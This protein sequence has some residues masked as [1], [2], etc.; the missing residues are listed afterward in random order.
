MGETNEHMD[1]ESYMDFENDIFYEAMEWAVDNIFKRIWLDEKWSKPAKGGRHPANPS[2]EKHKDME[3]QVHIFSGCAMAMRVLDYYYKQK[4]DKIPKSNVENLLKR[5]IFGYLYHD[6][7]KLT[8]TDYLMRD[9]EPLLN[10]VKETLGDLLVEL[11]LTSEDVYQIATCTEKGTSFNI[12]SNEINRNNLQFESDFSR[13]ADSLSGRFNDNV[14]GP[15]ND[16]TFGADIIISGKE[17]AHIFVANTSMVAVTD[18]VRKSCISVIESDPNNFFLWSDFNKLYYKSSGVKSDQASLR[19]RILKTFVENAQRSMRPENLL[20]LNDRTVDNSASGFVAQTVESL[21]SFMENETGQGMKMCVYLEDIKLDSPEKSI[22][23]EKY[24]EALSSY[25]TSSFSLNYKFVRAKKEGHSLRDGLS[26]NSYDPSQEDERLHIFLIRYTQLKST[27]NSN[28]AKVVRDHIDL[29]IDRNLDLLKHLVGKEPRKSVLVFPQ[30]LNDKDI[31]WDILLQDV[32]KDLNVERKDIDNEG[33]MRKVLPGLF[34][35]SEFPEVPSKFSMSM[36]NGYPA[37]EEGKGDKLFGINTN[38]FNNRLPTSKIGFGKVD[39]LSIYEYSLRRNSL[40]N[41]HSKGTFTYLRFP[42]AIPHL[43]LTYI[44]NKVTSSG[45]GERLLLNNIDLSID[46]GN[47][48]LTNQISSSDSILV[49][50][51][52]IGKEN[53]VIRSLYQTIEFAMKTKMH[54][55]VSYANA[56]IFDDQNEALRFEISSSILS[57]FSWNSIRSNQ[58]IEVKR[59]IQTFNL[60]VNGSLEK[61]NF[62]GTTKVMLDYI[63]QPMSI[64]FHVHNFLFKDTDRPARGFGKQFSQRIDEIRKLGYEVKNRG[65]KKM[66]KIKELAE[67]ASRIQKASWGSSSS[68][69]TWMIMDP[70]EAIDRVRVKAKNGSKRPLSDFRDIIGGVLIVKLRRDASSTGAWVPLDEVNKFSGTLIELLEEDFQGKIPTGSL[71]SYLINAFEFEYM[72]TTRD[73]RGEQNDE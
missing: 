51:T 39:D 27:F 50:F 60:V 71:K 65:D 41:S 11:N 64:F 23:A 55:R 32:L 37:S 61:I 3:Y 21:K 58:F 47:L 38:G 68:K 56:P 46:P 7:N 35:P 20:R 57:H 5:G 40:R 49:S 73:R 45:R 72:L 31:E 66:K 4:P 22:A 43:N 13:L 62:D 6:Y 24:T 42:G 53:E 36:V 26:I 25:N 70:L 19:D 1:Y 59:T 67:I 8:G 54:A 69:R 29:A 12:L 48:K 17:L 63:L 16:I 28:A 2:F 14:E 18:I 30:I 44:L 52:E 15:E 10:F 9:K 34:I 33:I